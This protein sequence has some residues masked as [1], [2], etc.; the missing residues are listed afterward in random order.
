MTTTVPRLMML[1]LPVLHNCTNILDIIVLTITR[2]FPATMDKEDSL[3]KR[4][5]L[6]L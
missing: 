6:I 3:L 5:W 2:S 4:S 1:H